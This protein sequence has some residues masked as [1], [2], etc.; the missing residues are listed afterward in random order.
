M[1]PIGESPEVMAAYAEIDLA[2]IGIKKLS[3][4]DFNDNTIADTVALFETLIKNKKIIDADYTKDVVA[5]NE[6]KS[7]LH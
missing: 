2:H 4:E 6:L 5:M 1:K 7:L 3:T